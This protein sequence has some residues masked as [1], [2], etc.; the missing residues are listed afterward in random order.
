MERPD[1]EDLVALLVER[2]GFS[3]AVTLDAALAER[4]GRPRITLRLVRP[5]DGPRGRM[6]YVLDLTHLR[7]GARSE[8]WANLV[9][10][11]DALVGQ[12]VETGW[13]HREL[14]VGDDVQYGDSTFLVSVEME[15]PELDAIADHLLGGR[16]AS[17][18]TLN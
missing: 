9:D 14:P 11:L 8:A 15:R 1:A 12:L 10:A 18:P 4:D 2:H 3:S 7:G 5:A 17:D 6:R 16:S 13:A